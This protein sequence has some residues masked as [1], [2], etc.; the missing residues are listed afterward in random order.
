MKV[1]NAVTRSPYSGRFIIEESTDGTTYTT[2]YTSS[3][4]EASKTWTPSSADV[5]VI[6][7]TLYASGGVTQA[8]DTQSV[9]ITKD[10]EDGSDG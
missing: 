5:L 8:L 7:G 3:S 9:V 4:N 2:V 6:K 10:G 1:G